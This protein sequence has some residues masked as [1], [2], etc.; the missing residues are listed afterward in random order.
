M[1]TFRSLALRS[2]SKI[3]EPHLP[4]RT[5]PVTN[6][7]EIRR[8]ERERATTNGIAIV[9]RIDIR[10]L[11]RMDSERPGVCQMSTTFRSFSEICRDTSLHVSSNPEYTS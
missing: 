2:E 6:T 11:V 3:M 5:M 1:G 9:P 10:I 4:N 7:T 8:M